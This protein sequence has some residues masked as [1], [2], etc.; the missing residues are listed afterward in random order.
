MRN[1]KAITNSL[2]KSLGIT[3]DKVNISVSAGITINTGNFESF[4]YNLEVGAT[5]SIKDAD[6]VKN[7]LDYYINEELQKI[8][9]QVSTIEP[10]KEIIN[11]GNKDINLE[12]EDIEL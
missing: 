4:K 12:I 2:L 9:E 1:K 3:V 7:N 6:T 5:C 10:A 11:N 8:K